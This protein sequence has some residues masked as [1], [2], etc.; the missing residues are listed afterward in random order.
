M[1]ENWK[2]QMSRKSNF[3][4]HS[5]MAASIPTPFEEMDSR[6]G[7][8]GAKSL[9]LKVKI[10]FMTTW[11]IWMYRIYRNT[12]Q[13]LQELAD[14][15]TKPLFMIFEN[16]WQSAHIPGGWKKGNIVPIFSNPRKQDHGS[17]LLVSLVSVSGRIRKQILLEIV[18]KH[19]IWDSQCSWTKARSCLTNSVA[20]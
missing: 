2:Q 17:Y 15:F 4:P 20:F 9:P 11:G 1:L 19:R 3:L 12:Y 14:V 18:L 6:M 8:G 16:F 10:R 5:S 13:S 7:T